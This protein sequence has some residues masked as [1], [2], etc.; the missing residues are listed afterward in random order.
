[1][2][3]RRIAHCV[4]VVGTDTCP[5]GSVRDVYGSLPGRARHGG[6]ALVFA[7]HGHHLVVEIVPEAHG[8]ALTQSHRLGIAGVF[9]VEQIDH[10]VALPSLGSGE[11]RPLVA[12]M[13]ESR[14]P[15]VPAGYHDHVRIQLHDCLELRLKARAGTGVQ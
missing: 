7:Y 14:R 5:A 13:V 4:A 12:V 2:P 10:V 1:M 8:V 6:G 15:L 9:G 3:Q 11:G